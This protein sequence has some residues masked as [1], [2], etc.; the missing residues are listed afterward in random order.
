MNL[1]FRFE[2][3]LQDKWTSKYSKIWKSATVWIWNYLHGLEMC[4]WKDHWDRD[5]SCFYLYFT[6]I[7]RTTTSAPTLGCDLLWHH[8]SKAMG[9]SNHRLISYNPWAKILSSF[10][11]NYPQVFCP[12]DVSLT[13]FVIQNLEHFQYQSFWKPTWMLQCIKVINNKKKSINNIIS[14]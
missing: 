4:P 14:L 12:T 7:S 9:S 1:V 5:C 6:T 8:G 13:R 10:S 3:H 11:T 2:F